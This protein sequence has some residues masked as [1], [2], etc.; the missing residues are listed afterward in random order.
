MGS[1]RKSLFRLSYL[2][3]NE[4]EFS[5]SG[6]M[7]FQVFQG[8]GYQGTWT[9][10]V[11]SGE[12]SIYI[13][14]SGEFSDEFLGRSYAMTDLSVRL[15]TEGERPI[16]FITRGHNFHQTI[17]KFDKLRELSP[18]YMMAELLFNRRRAKRILGSPTMGGYRIPAT[19]ISI[20][21]EAITENG[22][23][24]VD[25]LASRDC[26]PSYFI[27]KDRRIREVSPD[28]GGARL[29]LTNQR[30]RGATL[31]LVDETGGLAL[32]G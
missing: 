15:H 17:N 31:E 14:K 27:V 11:E 13:T 12:S 24:V 32:T 3:L 18:F 5:T 23:Y 8:Q 9:G 22:P 25:Y 29:S 7:P 26:P 2:P 16:D 30:V 10:E 19:Q 28:A 21:L 4:S 20:A 1:K 6:H